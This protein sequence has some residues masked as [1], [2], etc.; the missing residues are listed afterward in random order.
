M[1]RSDASRWSE[2]EAAFDQVVDCSAG[3]R[4]AL[5]DQLRERSPAVYAEVVSLL[6]FSADS[7]PFL[8]QPASESLSGHPA[9]DASARNVLT[10]GDRLGAYR[11]VSLL[12][13]G[14]MGEVYRAER[15]DGLYEQEVAL[16]L[17]RRDAAD[18][19]ARFEAE[20]QI[21]ATL[22]HPGIA[23]LHDAGMTADGQP[24]IV[25][26]LVEGQ[27]IVEWCTAQRADLAT[28]LRLFVEVCEATAFAHRHLVIHRDLKPANVLV[29]Q[30][31][32]IKLLDF[33]AAKLL[34]P[35]SPD[36]TAHAPVTPS[37]ASPEQLT[38][39]VI[40]TATDVHALGLLLFELL[41]GQRPWEFGTLPMVAA[42]DMIVA[43]EPS[44]PSVVA[45]TLSSPP[46]APRALQGDL[47][48]IVARALRKEPEHRY[49]TP[50]ALRED[51]LR[52]LQHEPV[53]AR[54]G[55]WRYVIGRA[56]RRHRLL[57]GSV[58]TV[59]L[60]VT[61]GAVGMAWQ[62]Q[63]AQ[64]EAR[65]AIAVRDFVV[66]IFR[67]NSVDNP[68]GA[69]GRQTTAIELLN[70]GAQAI[71]TGLQEAPEVRGALIETLADL[72]DQMEEFERV[73]TL[74][75]QYLADLSAREGAR[76][77]TGR[78]AALAELGRAL[79]MGDH[80]DEAIQTL[81][82]ALAMMDALGDTRSTAR[83]QALT[84]LGLVEYHTRPVSDPS[85]ARHTAAALALLDQ[86]QPTS[87]DR[88]SATQML[89]RIAERR[90]DEAA[91]EAGYRRFVA[92]A[93]SAPFSEQRVALG[94]ALNDLG[95]YLLARQRFSEAERLLQRAVEVL[96]RAEGPDQL[97]AADARRSLAQVLA[98]R[99]DRKVAQSLL[100]GALAAVEKTS[101][102]QAASATAPAR[103][104][105]AEFERGRGRWAVAR[106]LFER[107]LAVLAPSGSAEAAVHGHTYTGY[108]RVLLDQGRLA[109]AA[110]ALAAS[111][112]LENVMQD[113]GSELHVE[114]RVLGAAIAT[115]HGDADGA[116]RTLDHVLSVMPGGAAALPGAYFDA[117]LWRIELQ[118]R[119]GRSPAAVAAARA[120]LARVL[121]AQEPQYL[122]DREATA[123]Q[124]LGRALAA[125]GDP[126]AAQVEFARA[127]HLR[128]RLDDATS[129]ALAVLRAQYAGVLVELHERALARSLL[130][131]AIPVLRQEPAYAARFG[132][133]PGDLHAIRRAPQ[134]RR[135]RVR[136][137]AMRAP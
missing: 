73:A 116:A 92:L 79:A 114:N 93:E 58:A 38:G 19:V 85:A 80:Y 29:T 74:E 89:A 88:L 15:A 111:V 7:D 49:R 13:T 40:T 66:N 69:A 91:A 43:R 30:A 136:A 17:I 63:R 83:T 94:C 97:D 75:R 61:L 20:R 14:G 3:Q 82:Q 64:A 121:G 42:V 113:P 37:Y 77:S 72:Y 21:L 67:S 130:T 86:Y 104:T 65:K 47:D 45:R 22:T 54:S 1:I 84:T 125:A 55:Q 34:R 103:L 124:F 119:Q 28:R 81:D 62:A 110:Q 33:G 25:M 12:G 132:L 133:N 90:H 60:A 96:D 115:L 48:A 101:T 70:R 131:Q 105:L 51:I 35:D 137:V 56:L 100:G 120:L 27:P 6:S 102:A 2:V 41:T 8:D 127:A 50:D 39:G 46:V 16:K 123:R 44:A 134:H 78:A 128:E 117:S 11:I 135:V 71:A 109:E 9:A 31:G 23:R 129:P 112:A 4:E 36:Q 98:A 122:I 57:T 95:S 118:L 87:P 18:Q 68:D 32:G 107:N 76:P 10:A 108:A 5:L 53:A 99:G 106:S 24:Y 59:L 126:G 52:H 26:E